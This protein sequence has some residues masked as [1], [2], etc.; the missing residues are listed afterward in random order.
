[1]T[2]SNQTEGPRPPIAAPHLPILIKAF[3]L[4]EQVRTERRAGQAVAAELERL[5]ALLA[6]REKDLADTREALR[7]REG[8]L[9]RAL[10][11]WRDLLP[12]PVRAS[13]RRFRAR[14]RAWDQRSQTAHSPDGIWRGALDPKAEF[15][16]P[17]HTITGW[18][19][20]GPRTVSSVEVTLN[21]RSLGLARVGLARPDIAM[22]FSAQDAPAAGFQMEVDVAEHLRPNESEATF[23][24]L[25]RA[26]DGASFELKSPALR[27]RA[28]PADP[29]HPAPAA[30]RKPFTGMRRLL[31]F[32]HSLERGGAQI[33]LVELLKRLSSSCE[34]IT[35]VTPRD[36]D[37]R[38]ELERAGVEVRVVEG[39][40]ESAPR[41][42]EN[43][44]RSFADLGRR[45]GVDVVMS[46]TMGASLGV[47]V[48][49]RLGVPSVW[50]IHESFP[51]RVFWK[52]GFPHAIDE[53]VRADAEHAL[54][55]VDLAVFPSEATRRLY[56]GWIEPE[57]CLVLP[58][59]IDLSRWTEPPS[60]QRE[61][62]R[63]RFGLPK[64]AFVIV[65]VGTIEPRKGQTR[66][67]QAFREALKLH[68][69]ARL[70]LV[71]EH[72][73]EGDY[74]VALRE[75]LKR[76]GIADAVLI[77]PLG[78]EVPEWFAAADL[79]VLASD[80]EALPFC[81]IEAMAS[82][83]PV[84]A[85]QVFGVPELVRDGL[86]GLLFPANDVEA[87]RAALDRAISMGP[88]ARRRLARAGQTRVR[89]MDVAAYAERFT[90]AIAELGRGASLKPEAAP[91]ARPSGHPGRKLESRL[92][93]VH[94]PRTGGTYVDRYLGTVL[95]PSG[96]ALY[97]AGNW[98]LDRDWSV[99][100]LE[101]IR[102]RPDRLAYVHN[103]THGWTIEA[104]ERYR[105]D[106]WHTFSFFRHPGDQLCSFFFWIRARRRRGTTTDD[107]AWI[108]RVDLDDFLKGVLRRERLNAGVLEAMPW[109]PH[110]DSLEEF[111]ADSFGRF[112]SERLGHE[113]KPQAP[114]NS[115]GNPGWS[116]ARAQ[117]L[118]SDETERLLR[119]DPMY[120]DYLE[121]T[122]RN[123]GKAR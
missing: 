73:T 33:Y 7:N 13:L 64:D 21:G 76:S 83:V 62:V 26:M 112:L 12:P 109:A 55:R 74:S 25:V 72:Q 59:G 23:G 70:A 60:G 121:L 105:K 81:L 99:D 116:Q 96:F 80:I 113:Y 87:L 91:I 93:F 101:E 68:P 36:G 41:T 32:T 52:V 110:L 98:G 45:I 69:G 89:E 84:A 53:S 14:L 85:S 9:T 117:G 47:E 34:S 97:N 16:G 38:T 19:L 108:S 102:K 28:D 15:S 94:I 57:R 100:E 120:R 67:V 92:A 122:R 111:G 106:G 39:Y 48:A 43:L 42:R 18:A 31:V 8:R 40:G 88:E 78:D 1:V 90:R 50:A 104:L 118:V 5:H 27:V 17:V 2:D 71:G 24:V 44:V 54:R 6:V 4:G 114:V 35:V 75:V 29:H 37:L 115:S 65:S 20:R 103:H 46:N 22:A 49:A 123:G 3:E 58:Y 56:A 77:R 30:P 79:V 86:E 63:A 66:L 61:V 82:G 107:W 11:Q 10:A 119:E 95:D 51:P